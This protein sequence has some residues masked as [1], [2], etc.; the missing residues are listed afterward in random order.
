MTILHP[1]D[2]C[3]FFVR[4]QY[5]HQLSNLNYKLK[6]KIQKFLRLYNEALAQAIADEEERQAREKEREERQKQEEA[7]EEKISSLL[8]STTNEVADDFQ[9]DQRDDAGEPTI[10]DDLTNQDIEA[11]PYEVDHDEDTQ[12]NNEKNDFYHVLLSVFICLV[13][14]IV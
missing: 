11:K 14:N 2:Q 6:K 12:V 4:A 7:D 9:D 8:L 5:L 1:I 3:T 10:Q 13:F